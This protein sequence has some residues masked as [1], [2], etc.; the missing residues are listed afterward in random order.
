MNR[1]WGMV[2]WYLFMVSAS[3]FTAVVALA[4]EDTFA[5]V[6]FTFCALLC[7]FWC[8]QEWTGTGGDAE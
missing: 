6:A 2:A 1:S 8:W 7:S 5:V 3:M 4:R